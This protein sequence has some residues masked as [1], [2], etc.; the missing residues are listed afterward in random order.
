MNKLVKIAG[1]SLIGG[2]AILFSLYAGYKYFTSSG[3]YVEKIFE[4]NERKMAVV[5]DDRLFFPRYW[6]QPFNDNVDVANGMRFACVNTGYNEKPIIK[7]QGRSNS[8]EDISV[9]SRGYNVRIPID[10]NKFKKL[11]RKF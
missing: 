11:G 1:N 8:G 9:W 3:V 6:V 7:F 2:L 5:R 4:Q 10:T